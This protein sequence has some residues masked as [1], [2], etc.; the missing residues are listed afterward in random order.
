MIRECAKLA[1]TKTP[2]AGFEVSNSENEFYS[3]IE[4]QNNNT[5]AA[6][7]FA[8][9]PKNVEYYV[10]VKGKNPVKDKFAGGM[11]PSKYECAFD[12]NGDLIEI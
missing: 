7:G 5:Q 6:L 2:E 9:M 8:F 12:K 1:D 3:R 4:E 11:K 10:V